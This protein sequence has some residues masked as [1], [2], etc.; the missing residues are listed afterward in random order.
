MNNARPNHADPGV[1]VG[2]GGINDRQNAAARDLHDVDGGR[3]AHKRQQ[4]NGDV[5]VFAEGDFAHLAR[6]IDGFLHRA[7]HQ[8][9]DGR[10]RRH[11]KA[12]DAVGFGNRAVADI[13]PGVFRLIAREHRAD[14]LLRRAG[15]PLPRQAGNAQAELVAVARHGGDDGAVLNA[16]GGIQRGLTHRHPRRTGEVVAAGDKLEHFT[17]LRHRI[18]RLDQPRRQRLNKQRGARV[19]AVVA[20]VAHVQRLGQHQAQVDFADN[21]HRVA[22]H[23][24]E[25]VAHPVQALD[26]AL[27][28]SPHAQDLRHLLAEV[29]EGAVAVGF[30]LNDVHKHR[31]GGDARHRAHAVMLVARRERNISGGGDPCRIVQIFRQPFKHQRAGNR[32]FHCPA[33]VLPGDG[34]TGVQNGGAGH[35]RHHV[36]GL[37]IAHQHRM[38]LNNPLK[39]NFVRGGN[40]L[41]QRFFRQ[42]IQRVHHLHIALP[43]RRP[44]ELGHGNVLF[45]EVVAEHRNPDVNHVQRLVE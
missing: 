20:L 29:G 31:R 44:V 6:K 21:L 23:R 45:F 39:G 18:A 16:V 2:N 5:R 15:E 30:V 9:N 33:H 43:R 1:L 25:H 26:H 3:D 10:G 36:D 35:A 7:S 11:C 34:R 41:R 12:A 8:R 14:H 27:V 19:V 22:Q 37:V 42:P 28:V 32:A 13:Q 17:L 4:R 40:F 24:A 38:G